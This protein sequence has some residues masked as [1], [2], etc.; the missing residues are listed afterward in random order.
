MSVAIG[1]MPGAFGP[2]EQDPHVLRQ[3]VQVGDTYGYDSLWL[4]GCL[5]I[6]PASRDSTMYPHPSLRQSHALPTM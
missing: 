2:G 1:Y 3:L 6:P 5:R 4:S